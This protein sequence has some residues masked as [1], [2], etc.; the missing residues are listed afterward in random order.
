VIAAK[1]II[2]G[3]GVRLV[4]GVLPSMCCLC[5]VDR[6]TIS[7]QANGAHAYSSCLWVQFQLSVVSAVWL[8]CGVLLQC[9]TVQPRA[10]DVANYAL[11]NYIQ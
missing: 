1:G 11:Q 8:A 6:S 9:R 2:L 5:D 4:A 7:S 10:G 3:L